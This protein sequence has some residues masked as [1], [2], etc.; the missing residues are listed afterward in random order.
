MRLNSAAQALDQLL[1]PSE[2]KGKSK[3]SLMRAMECFNTKEIYP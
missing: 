1:I 2:A 3:A